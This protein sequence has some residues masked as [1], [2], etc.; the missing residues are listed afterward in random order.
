MKKVV[1][2]LCFVTV[3][4][5]SFA[6]MSTTRINETSYTPFTN[7]INTS[8][9][10]ADGS[11]GNRTGSPGDSGSTCTG[12]HS[13]DANFSLVPTITTDIPIEGYILEQTYLITISTT[14]TGASGYGFELTAE[15]DA[16]NLKAGVFDTTGSTGL[17]KVIANGQGAGNVTQSEDNF[18]SWSFNWIAPATNEGAITFYAA[19][20]AADGSGTDG[21]QTVT[22]SETVNSNTLSISEENLLAFDIYPN[23]S[24]DY[25][26]ILLPNEISNGSIEIFDYSGKSVKSNQ[27]S[28]ADNTLDISNLSQGIYFVKLNSEGK[29]GIQKVIKK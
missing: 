16:D 15:K 27:I 9:L 29:T 17:P 11:P 28:S 1:L 13:G 18:S 7:E 25:L 20:L 24:Q 21:D 12:C 14:S 2:Y 4:L 23:P 3:V 26:T 8:I 22:T 10:K 6:F 19:V 5:G